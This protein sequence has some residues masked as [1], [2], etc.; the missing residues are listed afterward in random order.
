MP[1]VAAP[2]PPLPSLPAG[3]SLAPTLPTPSVPT[4]ASPAQLPC[5]TLPKVPP[6]T[7]PS[8]VGP[9]VMNPAF[10]GA[11]R[12]ATQAVEQFLDALPLACPRT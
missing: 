7:L 10:V 11:L 9:L 8:P 4:A 2:T 6:F 12:A 5:C 3:L 1:C